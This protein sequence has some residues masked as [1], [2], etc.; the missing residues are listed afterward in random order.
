MIMESNGEVC[1]R[2]AVEL[3]AGGVLGCAEVLESAEIRAALLKFVRVSHPDK[4]AG[5]SE[6]EREVFKHYLAL[7]KDVCAFLKT[8]SDPWKVA[9]C[10]SAERVFFFKD[11]ELWT[12]EEAECVAWN[13]W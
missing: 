6:S 11:S 5:Q 8:V 13:A 12:W 1:A 10:S 4:V 2:Y 3:R 9:W 7:L